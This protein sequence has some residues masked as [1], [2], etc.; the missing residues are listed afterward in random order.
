MQRG[1][2]YS[3][4]VRVSQEA[5]HHNLGFTLVSIT[6]MVMCNTAAT[7]NSLLRLVLQ[8]KGV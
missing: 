4:I 5:F 2:V 7:V 8:V 1:L 3:I 6:G